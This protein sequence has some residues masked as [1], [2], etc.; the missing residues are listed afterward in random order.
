MLT[1]RFSPPRGSG[2]SH[3]ASFACVTNQDG[4][5]RG[6]ILFE[7]FYRKPA[8]EGPTIA[9]R[10]A[11]TLKETPVPDPVRRRDDVQLSDLMQACVSPNAKKRPNANAGVPDPK[12][13]GR[14]TKRL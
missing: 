9:E 13:R 12:V 8:I 3:C 14:T 4:D 6:C 10:F 11:A 7:A 5:K 2:S 1:S